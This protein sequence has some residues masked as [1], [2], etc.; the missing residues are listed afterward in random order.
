MKKTE[1]LPL[2][3][4]KKIKINKNYNLKSVEISNLILI[5]RL[6]QLKKQ[7]NKKKLSKWLQTF[8]KKAMC[9]TSTKVQ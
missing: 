3:I 9:L 5:L 7:T 1:I 8:F 2:R 6:H 4:Q